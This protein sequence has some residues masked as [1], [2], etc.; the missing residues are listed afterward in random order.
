MKVGLIYRYE[1]C[2]KM[3]RNGVGLVSYENWKHRANEERVMFECGRCGRNFEAEGQSLIHL[4]AVR[5]KRWEERVTGGSVVGMRGV[6]VG[7][8]T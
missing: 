4:G 8:I 5:G 2:G 3:C 7:L 1:G 6:L